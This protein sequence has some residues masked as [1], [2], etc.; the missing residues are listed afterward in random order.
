MYFSNKRYYYQCMLAPYI[1][2]FISL[3]C[4]NQVYQSFDNGYHIYRCCAVKDFLYI[5]YDYANNIDLTALFI[6]PLVEC[7]AF[8][9]ITKLA[10]VFIN[11]FAVNF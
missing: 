8:D 7:V 4:Y 3:L 6:R 2:R 5:T 1:I 11:I 9:A 10:E